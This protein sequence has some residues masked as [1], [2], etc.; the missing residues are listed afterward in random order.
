MLSV[1]MKLVIDTV[2]VEAIAGTMN[3]V[4]VGGVVSTMVTEAL[5]LADTFPAASFAQ[6]Y[7]VLFP[8]V[9]KV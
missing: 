9:V 5:A 1:A 2:S 7:R 3:A 4:T 8:V 6:A